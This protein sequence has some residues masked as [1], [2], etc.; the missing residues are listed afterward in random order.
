M[1]LC[2]GSHFSSFCVSQVHVLDT[3]LALSHG[4]SRENNHLKES[5][6]A[7]HVKLWYCCENLCC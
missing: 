4:C 3:M 2:I 7:S 1:Q 5:K 6:K